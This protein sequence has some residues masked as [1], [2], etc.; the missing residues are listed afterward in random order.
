MMRWYY[1]IMDMKAMNI[2]LPADLHER[3]RREAFDTGFSM[4][5]L[6][7]ECIQDAFERVDAARRE[8]VQDP[9]ATREGQQP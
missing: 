7:I 2:R 4:N 5:H 3:L 1:S 9:A 6:I 8:T